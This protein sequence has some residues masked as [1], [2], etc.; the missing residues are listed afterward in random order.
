METWGYRLAC[1]LVPTHKTGV[2]RWQ[3]LLRSSSKTPL[4]T[5][6]LGCLQVCIEREAHLG[7]SETLA[8][9]ERAA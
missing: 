9:E 1:I 7:V 8:V 6:P 5:L 4:S 2:V 3:N